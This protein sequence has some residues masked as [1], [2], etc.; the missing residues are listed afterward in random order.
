MLVTAF[1]LPS[2]LSG[3]RLTPD[4]LKINRTQDGSD[5]GAATQTGGLVSMYDASGKTF[6][7]QGAKVVFTE[8]TKFTPSASALNNNAYVAVSG[9]FSAEGLLKATSIQIR[10][11]N[12]S[13][14]LAKVKLIGPISQFVDSSSFVVRGVP[15]DASFI[16]LTTACPSVTLANEVPVQIDAVQQAN[17]PVV[18]ATKM[19]CI[20]MPTLAI[21]SLTG[22]VNSVDRSIRQFVLT[23]DTGSAP[24][25]P[26]LQ[27]VVWNE[28]TTF[29]G[30]DAASL[31]PSAR[32]I[33]VEGY[34]SGDSL[35]AKVV[36]TT[37]A[38]LD[39]DK[40]QKQAQ[41]N[42]N[43]WNDYKQG[44]QQAKWGTGE[45]LSIAFN[46]VP[47]AAYESDRLLNTPTPD[48][49]V[50]G[51][52]APPGAT[53]TIKVEG[54]RAASSNLKLLVGTYSRYNN[55]GRDPVYFTLNS[56]TNTFVVGNFG[57]LV[58]IQYTVYAKPNPAS[59]HPL[60][61][62]FQQGFLRTPNYE[63]GKTT[64]ADW[65]NQ[66][67]KY[68]Y[69]PD[70]VMQSSRT[71]MVFSRTN[72]LAW[73]DNDQDMVL[74]TADQVLDV[75]DA[76]SGLDGSSETHRRNTNQFLMTQAEDGWM[77]ATNFRTAFSADAAKYAFTPL[78]AGRL[79]DSGNAWGVWHELGHLHQ[80]PW[81]WS[82]LGE[83]T[84]NIYSLAAKRALQATPAGLA[85][86]ESKNDTLAYLGS[87]SAGKNFN[88]ASISVW[89]KLYMFYQLWQAFGDP[90]YQQLH[91]QTREEKPSLST[92]AEKMRYFMLKACT[93]SGKDLTAFF[94]KWGL[95][96]DVVYTEIAALHLPAPTTD[97][98]LW[99][100]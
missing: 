72:A 42:S 70:V 63:L 2:D 56:G 83:V 68:A 15:V 49:R 5:K 60:T 10:Q 91:R 85:N 96:A 61:I 55:A 1:A 14:D 92:D 7:L 30:L 11:Q 36:N 32:T 45:P 4:H 3:N 93:I 8:N 79:P 28:K 87:S 48:F 41:S 51:L 78:I 76:V 20:A 35:I 74:N 94:K 18:L 31:S 89:V 12:N 43:A 17:T 9:T 25:N 16:N 57:G 86:N 46:E 69:T 64:K 84:V 44:K 13:T 99:T 37:G 66:L 65:K 90:F 67:S 73:Q 19:K 54:T 80:Q 62:T 24:A 38:G 39:D 59:L 21:Q 98:S 82:G 47:S 6:E 95:Q 75:E 22:T 33:R 34:M 23:K 97:P 88:T 52:Y 81:T 29:M 71:F 50:T 58:Y 27:K 100:E 77:Y 26:V 53:L 40:F